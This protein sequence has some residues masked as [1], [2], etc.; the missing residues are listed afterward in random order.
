VSRSL[1]RTLAVRFAATMAVGLAGAS[2]VI[3]WGAARILQHQLDQGLAAASFI[4]GEHLKDLTAGGAEPLL[5]AD[6]GAYA[7]DVNRYLVLRDGAGQALHA[8]PRWAADLPCDTAV[9]RRA[10]AGQRVWSSGSWRDGPVRT[11][12]RQAELAGVGGDRVIQVAASLRPIRSV[13]GRL[14]AVLGAVIVLGTGATL[15]GAWQLAGSAVRPV[16]EITDQATHIQAGTLDQ[17]IAAHADTD[18]YR[19][20]V[21]VL[22]RMLER[23]DHAFRSQRRL[24]TDVSHEL[25]TPLTALRGEMEVALRAERSPR[26]YQRVLRSGLEEIDRLTAMSED[27]LLIT[28]AE[29][30]LIEPQR[31][32]TDVNALVQSGVQR[33]RH[34]IEERDLTVRATLDPSGAV[35]AVDPALMERLVEQLLE[36]AVKFTPIGGSIGVTT[37]ASDAVM[38]L[39]VQDSGSGIA[40]QDLPHVFEPFYR[41]DQA[42]ST[43]TGLGLGLSVAAAITRLHGGQIRAANVNGAGAR[44]EVELPAPAHT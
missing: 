33:L 17:R 32:P 13:Q 10:A 27:L 18:E 40:P 12:Y 8:L 7:R 38:R 15:V 5:A 34:V 2:A 9:L 35:V 39:A 24:T 11:F 31:V 41:A 36:N 25:R 14:L 1:R 22:N 21:A 29:A 37:Q 16:G 30:H 3:C 28:R 44:F 42:R 4:Y 23:L 26:E 20:L 43:G 19:G 6:P